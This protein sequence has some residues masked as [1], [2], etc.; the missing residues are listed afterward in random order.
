MTLGLKVVD[1]FDLDDEV[2]AL[3]RPGEALP[4]ADGRPRRL[5]RFFY[6]VD[7]YKTA[8]QTDLT[9][10]FTMNEFVNVDVRETP[11]LRAWPRY[12]PCAVTLLAAHLE[13]V[14]LA[15]GAPVHVAANGGYRSPAHARAGDA[16]PHCW[17]AAADLFQIGND[18]LADEE[19]I[20]RYRRIAAGVLPGA[21]VRPAED[22]LHVELGWVVVVPPGGPG[23]ELL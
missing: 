22:H 14:R 11:L 7:S 1:A 20:E 21:W 6:Q 4:E 3:L 15:V 19:T 17:G 12:V 23:E 10:H 5:P 9:A 2:R 18:L 8:R 13:L 16:S